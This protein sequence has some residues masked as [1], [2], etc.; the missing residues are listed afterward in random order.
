MEPETGA[1]I[2]DATEDEDEF[3]DA[4]PEPATDLLSQM[5]ASSSV[6]AS[7]A[8]FLSS[9]GHAPASDS[10]PIAPGSEGIHAASGTPGSAASA[11]SILGRRA[12]R[13]AGTGLFDCKA[14]VA[15][16]VSNIPTNLP[17]SHLLSALVHDAPGLGVLDNLS[18]RL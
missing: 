13:Q 12:R 16:L 10:Q 9:S 8:Q 18:R 14:Q 5:L 15:F 6:V 17:L 7:D 2:A 4:L 1:D 3:H 11:S